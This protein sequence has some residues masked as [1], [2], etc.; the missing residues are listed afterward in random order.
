MSR[1]TDQRDAIKTLLQSVS[2]IGK[3]Y[4]KSPN[5][6]DEKKFKDDYV[7]NG[8]VNSVFVVRGDGTETIGDIG[9]VDETREIEIT[10]KGDFWRITLL[11]GYSDGATPSEDSF[12]TLVDAIED[13]FRFLQNLNSTAEFSYP[14][15]RVVSG[16][17]AF[18]GDILCH[19]A[20]WRLQVESRIINQN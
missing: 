14:L 18:F 12:Q 20:E 7:V 11:Y 19:K 17:F 2:G 1:Y 4:T 5:T 10:Q 8:V 3:V 16:V 15:Q 6:T 13:K 9:S